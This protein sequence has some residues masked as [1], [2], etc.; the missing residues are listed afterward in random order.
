MATTQEA[1]MNFELMRR[2][3]VSW[4]SVPNWLS[5]R[6]QEIKDRVPLLDLFLAH[7]E[8]LCTDQ[9]DRF[10]GL[11]SLA[12]DCCTKTTPADYRKSLFETTSVVTLHHF[13]RYVDKIEPLHF[14]RPI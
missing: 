7:S 6:R 3:V 11:C 9:R 4:W 1:A 10:F 8:A 2:G 5:Q 14:Q 13:S 12:E